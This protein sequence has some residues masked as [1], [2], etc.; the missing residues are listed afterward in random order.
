MFTGIP[1]TSVDEVW[2]D[3][4]PWIES[5]C[6]SA[7][8]KF[9]PD[10]YRLALIARDMQLW[11]YRDKHGVA[12][13]CV[14][15]IVKYPRKKYCRIVIG[16]GRNRK[17]WQDYRKTIEEWAVSQGCDGM[18]SFARKGW[19]RIFTDYQTTHIVLERQFK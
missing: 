3:V 18:E 6:K 11:T 10:D 12:A 2:K 4:L 13:V 9:E 17:A 16:T 1:Y 14:T 19:A 15:E 8:G 7:R 5:A